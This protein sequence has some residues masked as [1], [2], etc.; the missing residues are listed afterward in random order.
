MRPFIIFVLIFVVVFG[1]LS[2]MYMF[3]MM[4]VPALLG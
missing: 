1:A 4:T 3:R 2:N